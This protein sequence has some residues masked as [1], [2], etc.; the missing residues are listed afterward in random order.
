MVIPLNQS[1]HCDNFESIFAYFFFL[2]AR[3]MPYPNP[4]GISLEVFALASEGIKQGAIA[5]CVSFTRATINHIHKRHA[6][7]GSLVPGK[8]SGAP[9]KT[10]PRQ[11]RA[12]LRM[13]RQDRFLGARAL[14]ALM[15]NLYE[16]RLVAQRLTTNSCP[17]VTGHLNPQ[18]S[19]CWLP[20]TI[21][22]A[23]SGRRGGGTKTKFGVTEIKPLLR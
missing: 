14:T 7:T 18:Q 8:S 15:R 11:D 6:A 2:F 22:S 16:M 4:M 17:V 10:T 20:T 12:L 13:V 5:A 1:S 21:V 3:T 19:P 23:W 9:R